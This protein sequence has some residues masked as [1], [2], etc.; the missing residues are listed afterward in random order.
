LAGDIEAD[1]A[2][3]NPRK[4]RPMA[5]DFAKAPERFPEKPDTHETEDQLLLE[6]KYPDKKVRNAVMMSVG[7]ARFS[8]KLPEDPFY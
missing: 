3:F 5:Y 2:P 4:P 7:E 1:I 8:E 6:I